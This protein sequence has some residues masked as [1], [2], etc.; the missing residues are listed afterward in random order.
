[1]SV[2][3]GWKLWY[4]DRT[5][6]FLQQDALDDAKIKQTTANALGALVRDGFTADSSKRY[7]A[8]GD[9]DLLEHTGQ[10]SVQLQPDD[11]GKPD[12]GTD[13]ED[14]KPDEGEAPNE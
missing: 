11:G 1:V 3:D 12:P 4:D 14:D 9:V 6:P 8:T 10:V 5:I 7:M 2:P 13:S